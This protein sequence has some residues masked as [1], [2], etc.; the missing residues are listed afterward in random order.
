M[1]FGVLTKFS[2]LENK[3]E[4]TK[5]RRR[6]SVPYK[7]N[8]GLECSRPKRPKSTHDY[9]MFLYRNQSKISLPENN[10]HIDL[11]REKDQGQIHAKKLQKLQQEEEQYQ[12]GEHLKQEH[13]EKQLLQEQQIQQEQHLQ[14]EQQQL[15]QKLQ[16]QH[17]QQLQH[18]QQHEHQLQPSR[19]GLVPIQP[20]PHFLIRH[21][22]FP[23]HNNQVLFY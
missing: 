16:L 13:L 5:R 15:Q 12:P 11:F 6:N 1:L 14:V 18:E 23:L 8:D 3:S 22:T 10:E 19:T 9:T 7:I 2:N 21:P 4:N 20:R 17:D